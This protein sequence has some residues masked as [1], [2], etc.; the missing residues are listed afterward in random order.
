MRIGLRAL[1]PA[2]IAA[3][4]LAV[5]GQQP[6][7]EAQPEPRFRSGVEVVNVAATVSDANGRF[8][9]GLTQN[10]FRVYEDGQLQT[11]SQFSAER[12][13]VSLGICLDTSGS[14]AGDKMHAAESALNRFLDDLIDPHDEVFLYRF[15]NDPVLLEGWTT[16]HQLIA[17]AL[18]RITPN[19]GTAMYDT[20]AEAVPLAQQGHNAKK[21]I[22]VISD[23]NDTASRVGLHEVKEL[24]RQSEVLMYAVGI[25]SEGERTY[26]PPPTRRPPIP[27]PFPPRGRPGWPPPPPTGGGSGGSGGWTR[28]GG[29]RVNESALRDMTDDTGGRTEIVRDPRDL[30]PA[31][32]SIA[33]EL[34]KQYFLAYQSTLK[35][36]GRWHDIRVEVN[37]RSYHVRARR[38]YVAS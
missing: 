35:R 36:D 18:G 2:M 8:V 26:R 13:P 6:P 1:V 24:L 34:S 23:G 11:I 38:G 5:H 19:G 16:D 14:M 37:D 15:S 4:A 9:P 32:A 31:T 22:V 21:A 20:V 27:F 7:A 30:D 17:R 3:A 29:E 12:V 10:D 25:D 33:D 28:I